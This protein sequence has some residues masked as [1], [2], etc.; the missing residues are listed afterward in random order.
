ML[1]AIPGLF[2]HVR[3]RYS[4]SLKGRLIAL[5]L[6][7][8][9]TLLWMLVFVS[10]SVQK[11]QFSEIL[12]DQQF[13]SVQRL[14]TDLD[15]K[16][17]DRIRGLAGVARK[18]P[19]ELTEHT[20]D[21][22]LS[23]LGG[24]HATF[25]AGIAV[26]GLDGVTIADYPAAPGRRGTYYGDRDYFIKAVA[27]RKPYIDKPIIGRALQRP[28]LTISVPVFDTDG[29]LR[30]VMTGITDLTAPNFLG[31]VSDPAQ[32]G[33]GEFFVIA[34]HDDIIVAA[35]D[36]TRA[37]MPAPAPG[38]NRMFDRFAAGFGGSGIAASSKGVSNLYSGTQVP[39]ARWVVMA[40]LPTD[41]AFAPV[42]YM[43]KLLIV[44]A[45][46]LT[47]LA[48][49]VAHWMAGR[50]LAPLDAAG[51][52]MRRI[53]QDRVPL[54]PQKSADEFGGM[55]DNFNVLV[56]EN[57]R[58]Q[59]ALLDSEQ[60]F[61]TLVEN[62]P[63]AIYVLTRGCFAY[64]N[65]AAVRLFGAPSADALLGLPVIERVP[66]E[67]R[68]V[69]AE[70]MRLVNEARESA[71]SREGT[72][73]R[74]DGG[75]VQVEVSAIPFFYENEPG[76]L[77]FVRDVSER[78][79]AEESLRESEERFHR[80]VALSSEWY[81]EQDE[82]YRFTN[83]SG[84]KSEKAR[85]HL[86]QFLGRTRWEMTP[87]AGEEIWKLHRVILDARLP[88]SEFEYRGQRRD[89]RVV[90]YSING[91]PLFTPDG[92]FRGYHGTGRTV[93]R[94]KM[95][96]EAL[97]HS[98]VHLRELAAHRERI[99]EEERKRIARD[100]HD[101][102]GQTLLALRIDVSMLAERTARLHPRLHGKVSTM[103]TYIDAATK[104]T[105]AIIN[106]LRPSVLDLGLL[107]A[108]EWQVHE[109]NRRTGVACALDVDNE[110]FDHGLDENRSAA[111]FR[112]LQ[113]SLSNISR[114]AQATQVQITVRTEGDTLHMTIA[115]DGVGIADDAP[116]KPNSFGLAGIEE[117]IHAL[118]G[119]FTVD[120]E[121]GRGTQLHFSVPLAAPVFTSLDERR[122]A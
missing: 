52:A 16:L 72:F 87:D 114:H 79:R 77:V 7:L 40:G 105:R 13:A 108:M 9:I 71:P 65:A 100:I 24:L 102:L 23:R 57:H 25:S 5:S 14:A 98:Q 50:L 90:W 49:L 56:E 45:A 38:A 21:P 107:A 119:S 58:S 43:Q 48:I 103:L 42:L 31:A 33:K 110:E 17:K 83:V 85:E 28:I 10:V 1:K 18:L 22:Y 41:V 118:G 115:D 120:S 82:H 97:R 12:F 109:F 80:L 54:A 75:V 76:A 121:A 86:E 88:F 91:E 2:A 73:V 30:A 59:A 63:D 47:A 8:C 27:T 67:L 60:R 70:R 94:R 117:R 95:A 46:V 78:K 32:S 96:E 61:R 106:D 3:R 51:R 19:D 99:K 84:W 36:T 89:G 122:S 101:D 53:V 104:S 29:N 35:T 116:R 64:V 20:L 111:L 62:A 113:E 44:A 39:I 93:T 37:M 4:H 34:P 26:I 55:V 6:G 66:A 15:S 68:P 74:L 81:W 92:V 69:V 112:I 11:R